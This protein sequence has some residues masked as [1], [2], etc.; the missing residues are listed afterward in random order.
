M[1][2]GFT[3]KFAG[4][5]EEHS[6]NRYIASRR[7]EGR[8]QE[9]IISDALLELVDYIKLLDVNLSLEDMRVAPFTLLDVAKGT[10]TRYDTKDSLVEGLMDE[11]RKSITIQRYKGL[12]EMNPGQL[13]ETTMDP[14]KRMMLQV[15]LEDAVAAEEI[16]DILMGDDVEPRKDFIKTHALEADNI[17]V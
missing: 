3:V 17:D 8:V 5:N 2:E 9:M 1:A 12:G 16:F 7:V 11:G 13:W 6:L 4:I 10:E 15:K 14:K